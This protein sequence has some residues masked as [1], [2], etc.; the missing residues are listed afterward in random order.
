MNFES[1]FLR[2]AVPADADRIMEI[3]S[4]AKAQM[5]REGK[6]QWS[7]AYP[8]L[9]D[10]DRDIQHKYG[11][12]LCDGSAV[13]AYA[14]IVYTGDSAY[15]QI[16][17]AW[18]NQHPYWVIHRLAVGDGYK[19]QGVASH[20]FELAEQK[21]LQHGITDLRVDTNYDN[22]Y[23]QQLLKRGGY[24][25]CGEIMNPNG[26]RMAYQKPLPL[27]QSSYWF[28][29]QKG[30]V[31]M[32][33]KADGT[34]H[35]PFAPIP[36]VILTGVNTVHEIPSLDEAKCYA[37]RLEKEVELPESYELCDLRASFDLLPLAEYK[38]AGHASQQLFWDDNTR[39]C[40]S[41]GS[42]TIHMGPI[43]KK[44]PCCG[45]SLYPPIMTAIMV[46][47]QRGED[48]ILMVHAHNFKGNYYGLIAGFLEPGETLEEC[49]EREVYEETHLK[50][51]NLRYLRSQ[52]WPYPS[53]MMV[54]FVADYASGEL[55]LQDDEL[56]AGG[57]FHRDH[58]PDTPKKLSL[59]RQMIEWW[60]AQK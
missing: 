13:L 27:P 20:F 50:I 57:F 33:K 2:K 53:G 58:L 34:Y 55:K 5:K 49:V 56:G 36:P 38:K 1:V 24:T 9:S 10:I 4:D 23:M 46:L 40:S 54:G 22:F 8:A 35:I 25:Y 42:P 16:E 6:N 44:C 37:C 47:I 30:S 19:R 31:L 15:Q 3:I 48:E 43:L 60:K 7:D 18:L 28:L 45:K 26:Q 41:C 29:F 17:G 21:A 59:A 51:K 14:A 52:S 39:F 32:E 12:V 11:Y